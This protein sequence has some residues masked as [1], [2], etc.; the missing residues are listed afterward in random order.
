MPFKEILF[1]HK[2][3]WSTYIHNNMDET[4]T[5]Y[6]KWK[7]PRHKRLHIIW[8]HLYEILKIEKFTETER[9]LVV[10]IDWEVGKDQGDM[11]SHC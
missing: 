2:M 1:S 8:L 9:K 7:K 11:G 10:A 4:W 5:Y 3:K 6:A